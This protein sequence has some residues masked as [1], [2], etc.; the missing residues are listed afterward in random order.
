MGTMTPVYIGERARR[1]A[2]RRERT[3]VLHLRAAF[4]GIRKRWLA[5]DFIGLPSV[6]RSRCSP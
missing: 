3:A 1:A 6:S 2:G 5:R 4:D